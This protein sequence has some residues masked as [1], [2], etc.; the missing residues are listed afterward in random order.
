MPR[1]EP[2]MTRAD[3]LQMYRERRDLIVAEVKAG[4]KTYDEIGDQFGISRA[5]VSQIA[6]KAGIIRQRGGNRRKP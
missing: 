3:Y 2:N 5:R 4:R 1:P 6:A